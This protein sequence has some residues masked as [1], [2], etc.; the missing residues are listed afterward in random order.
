MPGQVPDYTRDN[1]PAH[2]DSHGWSCDCSDDADFCKHVWA[3]EYLAG[4]VGRDLR[5]LRGLRGL[6]LYR[7]GQVQVVGD[8]D[9]RV[10]SR[11]HDRMHEVALS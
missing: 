1:L 11:C 6:A 2:K 10:K 7:D 9:Y 8:G 4:D 3:L 5:G